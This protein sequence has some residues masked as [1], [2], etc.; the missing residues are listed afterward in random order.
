M[1]DTLQ[2][3]QKPWPE[4]SKLVQAQPHLE[5]LNEQQCFGCHALCGCVQQHASGGSMHGGQSSW[6]GMLMAT[7]WG[8][9]MQGLVLVGGRAVGGLWH[10]L[11]HVWVCICIYRHAYRH[12]YT[13]DIGADMCADMPVLSVC[14]CPAC[15]VV[16]CC[17]AL[18]SSV[19]L[20]W[21]VGLCCCAVPSCCAFLLCC[22]AVLPCCAA[23]LCCACC[24]AL[25]L[26]M[27]LGGGLSRRNVVV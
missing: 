27:L 1:E 18:V 10:G 3:V 23:G 13:V 8:A 17:H 15:A 22:H 21:A 2:E 12:V 20:W 24:H 19:L 26:G 5:K 16:F 25:L 11:R 6:S 4:C 9:L 14:C 7:F